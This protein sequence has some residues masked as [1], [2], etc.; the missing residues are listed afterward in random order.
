MGG[1]I[2]SDHVC[3]SV[4]PVLRVLLLVIPWW[5]GPTF[6]ARPMSTR[7]GQC[8]NLSTSDMDN[9]S[10]L[11]SVCCVCTRSVAR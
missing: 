9:Y 11:L 7:H 5:E 4:D 6:Y 2:L 1:P 10:E 3:I 8:L